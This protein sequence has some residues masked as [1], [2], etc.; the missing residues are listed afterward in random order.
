MASISEAELLRKI[1]ETKLFLKEHQ[2]TLPEKLYSAMDGFSRTALAYMDQKGR[3]GWATSIVNDE[4]TPMWNSEQAEHLETLFPRSVQAGGSLQFGGGIDSRGFKITGDSSLITK[5]D[6]N[7]SLDSIVNQVYSYLQNLDEMNREFAKTIG[8]VAFVNQMGRD[9]GVGPILP[10]MPF[11]L[12]FPARLILPVL[13]SVLESVRILVST[14][15]FNSPLLRKLLSVVLAILDVS[16]GEWKNGILSIL[17]VFST[18]SL[19]VGLI[20]KTSR[21]I[22]NFISPDLQVRLESDIYKSAKSLFVGFWLWLLSV[23]SPD[24]IRNM[25]NDLLEKAKKAGEQ[26][27]KQ[28]DPIQKQA[29][30]AG[31]KMGLKVEFPE[32]PLKQMPSFDDIQNFQSLFHQPEV[33][34]NPGFQAHIQSLK[35]VPPL[36]LFL[37]L[38]NVPTDPKELKELCKDQPATMGEAIAKSLEPT[39]TPLQG[40]TRRKNIRRITTKR[41]CYT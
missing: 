3:K 30:E 36:R 32:L 27:Q 12:Q 6:I 5:P 18:E 14:Q 23:A 16:R 24:L 15:R 17:G 10:Y 19:F 29:I 25:I 26:A 7:I 4:N 2:D 38:L 33:I 13:N 1:E 22:Y 39:V 9:P 35:D 28:L 40:G 31:A 21:W 20:L 34:C 8:P 37:E 11:R 41:R